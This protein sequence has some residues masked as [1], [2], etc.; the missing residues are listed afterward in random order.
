MI[1]I[2]LQNMMKRHWAIASGYAYEDLK[3]DLKHNIRSDATRE[4]HKL[5]IT[6]FMNAVLNEILFF[7]NKYRD[8]GKV[9]IADDSA[10]PWRK[11]I[12]PIYKSHRK[13]KKTDLF[14]D[15]TWKHSYTAFNKLRN[16]LRETPMIVMAQNYTED[17]F[18][19]EAD[20]IIARL[21]LNLPN[22]KHLIVSTDKDFFQL[23]NA[24]CRQ[25]TPM[26]KKM[27]DTPSKKEKREWLE[28]SYLMGQ[29]KDNIKPINFETELSPDFMKWAKEKYEI[30]ID[31]TMLEKVR[32]SFSDKMEEYRMEK[33]IEDEE[34]IESKKRKT[35]RN[36][37][38]WKLPKFGPAAAKKFMENLEENLNENTKYIENYEL[39]K[40]LMD[41]NYLPDDIKELID[42]EYEKEL[43]KELD[44]NW[45]MN[46]MEFTNTFNLEKIQ[47]RE[48][49]FI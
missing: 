12:W 20:D 31:N 29:A 35:K 22:E 24:N 37:T 42:K 10:N 32:E 9:V 27:K 11:R 14:H 25:Y 26:L 13:E 15:I 17:G 49:E 18:G 4:E 28:E 33:S 45:L 2:D 34:L 8:Y 40:K 36:L 41:F 23:L 16:Q 1:L 19:L 30:E 48:N 6:G 47:G 3:Y 5:C 38:A 7:K 46:F 39:N 21:A 43:N 44:M